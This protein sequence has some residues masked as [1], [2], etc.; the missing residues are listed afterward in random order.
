MNNDN[1]NDNETE[2]EMTWAAKELRF[3]TSNQTEVTISRRVIISP[4]NSGPKWD[5]LII[6][7]D[8]MNRGKWRWECAQ[9]E[10]LEAAMDITRA[11]IKAQGDEKAREL[12]QLQ[13][14]AAK[15]GLKLVEAA[16]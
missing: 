1:D 9:A 3:I 5:Y 12:L 2:Q 15:L 8:L 11:Q 6:F 7:G 16:P 14:A 10:T 13:D 4:I